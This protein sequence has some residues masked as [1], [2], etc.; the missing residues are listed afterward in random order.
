MSIGVKSKL[1]SE[2][3]LKV[4]GMNSK[5]VKSEFGEKEF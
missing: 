5:F 4:S 3:L 2:I 1:E